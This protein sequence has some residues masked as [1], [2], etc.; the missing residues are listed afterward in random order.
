M[1]ES[2]LPAPVRAAVSIPPAHLRGTP[3]FRR[4]TLAL[5]AA[6]MTTFMTLYC[7]QALLP[8]FSHDLHLSPA[9]SSLTVSVSTAAMAVLVVP[10]TAVSDA[11]SRTGMMTASLSAAAVLGVAAAFAP[12]F[13]TL[14]VIRVLQGMALAGLQATA[15]SYLAEEVDRASLGQ[16]MGLY[17][18]GNGIGGMAGR[19]I[20]DGILDVTGSWRW[21]LGGV[22]VLA[23]V[24]ALGFR[25]LIPASVRFD[26]RDPNPRALAS[27]IARALPDSGLQRLYLVGFLAMAAFVTVY[28]YLGFRL[29]APPFGL[30]QAT[31]GLLFTTYIAGSFSSAT[32]GRLVDRYGRP[33]VL[34]PALAITLT[35]LALML[36]PALGAVVPGLVVFTVGFFAAHAVASSWVG[37]RSRSLGAQGAAVYLF[38]YYIGSAVGGSLGGVFYSSGAWNG[39]SAYCAV[40]IA[41]ALLSAVTLRRLRPIPVP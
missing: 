38:C 15:M 25:L 11:W 22:G 35:G 37:A 16:A 19:L 12:N 3:G 23:A 41:V 33:R 7:V 40:L 13:G 9:A 27:G 18:A 2:A 36:I 1:T 8:A 32:A 28:N 30:S 6:G 21:A 10:L 20:A 5:F 29:I 39:V 14:L 24:S 26:R 34:A 4:A 31:A 17:V